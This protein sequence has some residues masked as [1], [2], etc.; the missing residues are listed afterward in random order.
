[1]VFRQRVL[2][3]QVEVK[4]FAIFISTFMLQR[5]PEGKDGQDQHTKVA[6]VHVEHCGP[7]SPLPRSDGDHNNLHTHYDATAIVHQFLHRC[8]VGAKP[9]SGIS[10]S[11]VARPKY[12]GLPQLHEAGKTSKNYS[13]STTLKDSMIR[14]L[15][16]FRPQQLPW[17]QPLCP[18]DRPPSFPLQDLSPSRLLATPQGRPCPV[19]AHCV[20]LPSR[21]QL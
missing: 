15:S 11:L 4:G 5:P 18:Q 3:G 7:V 6:A 1:M 13:L 9:G 8:Q 19:E 14:A 10:W 2:L 16:H 17:F 12:S 21:I 20:S